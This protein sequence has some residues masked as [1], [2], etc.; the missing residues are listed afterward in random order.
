[1]KQNKIDNFRYFWLLVIIAFGLAMIVASGGGGG[2]DDEGDGEV[3][4]SYDQ[5]NYEAFKRVCNGRGVSA[6]GSYNE[7]VPG[8]HPIIFSFTC[9]YFNPPQC[10]DGTRNWWRSLPPDWYANHKESVGNIELVAC[11]SNDFE[12]IVGGPCKYNIGADIYRARHARRIVLRKGKTGT[13]IAEKIFEG[14]EPG[15]CPQTAPISQTRVYGGY[16]QYGDVENWLRA[17]VYP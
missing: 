17:Y 2:D 16:Y 3:V 10:G 11:V 4:K 7:N 12:V 9:G 13:G 15:P 1:M 6:A 8:P 5:I 14:S